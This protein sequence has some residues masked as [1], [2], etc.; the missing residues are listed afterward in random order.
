MSNNFVMK[1]MYCPVFF[2]SPVSVNVNSEN[3]H[4]QCMTYMGC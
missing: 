4:H 3:F 1:F 2:S